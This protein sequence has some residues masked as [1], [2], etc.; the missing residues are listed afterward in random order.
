MSNKKKYNDEEL[1]KYF[2]DKNFRQKKSKSKSNSGNFIKTI[3]LMAFA[4]IIVLAV[5]IF[6]LSKTLPS[7]AELENP[8]LEEATKIYSSDGELIDK[9]FLKNRTKVTLD[10]IPKDMIQALIATEDQKF[11][12]HWGVD[13][14]RI[15]KAFFKNIL[16]GSLTKEGASTIT[17]QLAR[18]LYKDIG[19]EISLNRKIREALTAVQI[20]RTYTKEEILAYYLN[21]VYFGKG[22]Y[23]VEAAAQTYFEKNAKDLTL[24][25]CA[26]LVATLKSPSNYD[27]VDNP[28]ASLKRRNLVLNEMYEEKFITKENLDLSVNDPL[29]INL[30]K[31]YA[32]FNSPAPQFTEYIRQILEKKAEKYGFDL[33]RDG[34]KVY[35]SLDTR[36]QKHAVDAVKTLLGPFQKSFNGYWNWNANKDILNDAIE[37]NIKQSENYKKAKTEQ[38]R[39]KIFDKLKS[40]KSFVDSVK[41]ITSTVQVGFVVM[42][43]KTGEIKAMIGAN[44]NTTFKYG[45]NHVTQIKRQPGSSFK[46]FVYATAINNGYSPGYMISNDPIT[47]NT[48]G[49]V[50]SPKGGGTGGS[51]TMRDGIANSVN[52][53][54]VRTAMDLAPMD[55]VIELAHSMGVKSELPNVL[56]LALGAGEV[57]PLEMTNA[58]GTFANEGIWVEPT[59]ILKI[60][61]RNGNIIEDFH[62]ETKEVLSEETAYIMSDMMEDVIDYGTAESIRRYFHRPAAGKTGTTQ[63][64]TDAWFVGFTPQFAA[65]VWLG[66]DDARIKFGGGYG[67]G[68]KAAAPIW[69]KFMQLLYSDDDFDFPVAYFLMPDGVEETSVCTVSGLKS[70]GT[71]PSVTDLVIKKFNQKKCNVFHYSAP[72]ETSVETQEPPKESVGY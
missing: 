60:E 36:F 33:Y 12:D 39:K 23:G 7:L 50:W 16:K 29:K 43:P 18:N 19:N 51:M 30:K 14:N 3:L 56:S 46:P 58:F 45:L 4:G 40:D 35:T 25:E 52:V 37:K 53:I 5:Y 38:E 32:N 47:V 55:K 27:P 10:N 69:G 8:K 34:L 31:D 62:P 63:N 70:N 66:F 11:Y 65:G 44:P 21:T 54:A 1:N 13:V 15:F 24:D 28:E 41:T 20:E 26:V 71:C 42:N 17:Q 2:S 49:Q 72:A 59:S 57:T 64:Y 9:F 6:Y 48:G 67:Q 68:G 61:D 22:A